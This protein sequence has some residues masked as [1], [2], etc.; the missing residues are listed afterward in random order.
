MLLVVFSPDVVLGQ[1]PGYQGRKLGL[2]VGACIQPNIG[3]VEALRYGENNDD[4]SGFVIPSQ[5][6]LGLEYTYK[7]R[8]SFNLDMTAGQLF[9]GFKIPSA[10]NADESGFQGGGFYIA[11]AAILT[12]NNFE[13]Q[14][15]QE[16][17][18]TSQNYR[19]G[20]LSI[21]GGLKLYSS[22]FIAPMGRYWLLQAGGTYV[23]LAS[24][25]YNMTLVEERT[26]PVL[27]VMSS[28][29]TLTIPDVKNRFFPKVSVGYGARTQ[30]GSTNGLFVEYQFRLGWVFNTTGYKIESRLIDERYQFES[31]S[32]EGLIY[33][34]A[35]SFIKKR[36]LV[37][38]H[39]NLGYLF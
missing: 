11:N 39:L 38:I 27:P 1:V 32:M 35:Y 31:D 26:G 16:I 7:L 9:L 12:P 17:R 34:T 28:N 8:A 14:P 22:K 29:G 21:D 3:Y 19:V 20:S 6:T 18:M 4:P 5:V 24:T 23:S 10:L 37:A 15:G 13:I 30:L 2:H 33:G 36:E 25:E